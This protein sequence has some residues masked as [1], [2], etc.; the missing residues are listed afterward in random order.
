[1]SSD[2]EEAQYSQMPTKERASVEDVNLFR[3]ITADIDPAIMKKK[4]DEFDELADGITSVF[5]GNVHN[6]FH[7]DFPEATL[8]P[9]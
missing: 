5:D 9:E 3:S 8:N 7:D 6:F 2:E 4:Q 1:M